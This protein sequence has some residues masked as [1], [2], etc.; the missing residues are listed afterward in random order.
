MDQNR[1][2]STCPPSLG[3]LEEKGSQSMDMQQ[4]CCIMM[5]SFR[6][7]VVRLGQ[8]IFYIFS[9]PPLPPFSKQ[10]S[11]MRDSRSTSAAC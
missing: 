1:K 7:V 8:N 11:E 3:V 4:L 2:D 10:S 9:T 5:F 6:D